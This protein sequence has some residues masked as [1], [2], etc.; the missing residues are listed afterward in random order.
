MNRALCRCLLLAA[1]LVAGALPARAQD[2]LPNLAW[3]DPPRE[4]PDVAY[5]VEGGATQT[6]DVFLGKVV[7]LNFWATWCPPCIAEMPSLDALA[8]RHAGDHLAVVTMAMD[9]AG[10]DKIREFY[11]RIQT[12]NLGIYRDPDM[13]L[14][15]ALR[16]FG[17]PTTLLIDH[18][19]NIVAQ[20]VGEADWSSDE[21]LADILP[22][23]DAARDA[24]AAM[25]DQAALSD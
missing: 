12:P 22:L 10:E 20:L 1:V 4:V 24:S 9:R 15:R 16:V 19:G 6:L 7:V 17:L 21:A 14:A 23:V 13:K 3:L 5:L 11:A 2:G 8:E 18:E 25:A